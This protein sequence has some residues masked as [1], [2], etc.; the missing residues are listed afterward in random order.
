MKNFGVNDL[1][2]KRVIVPSVDLLGM[3]AAP[4]SVIPAPGNNR[5]AIVQFIL[6]Q[7]APDPAL[8]YTGGG[9]VSLVYHGTSQAVHSGVVAAAVINSPTPTYNTL[10]PLATAI[11]PPVNTGIDITNAAGAFLTGDGTLIVTVWYLN[12]PLS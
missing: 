5:V 7:T 12:H 3:F 11:Q 10:P 1:I 2:T 8:S 6:V 4:W 9:A